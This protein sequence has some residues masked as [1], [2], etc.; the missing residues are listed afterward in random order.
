MSLFRDRIKKYLGQE[1]FL[2]DVNGAAYSGTLNE[3]GDDFCV[4]SIAK[5]Q[6]AYNLI[7]IVSVEPRAQA[8][9]EGEGDSQK[10]KKSNL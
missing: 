10:E 8:S 4:L 6:L 7:H 9:K 3:V 1:V 5:R 2:K